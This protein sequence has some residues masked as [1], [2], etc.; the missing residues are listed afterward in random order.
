MQVD[1]TD[2]V[3]AAR[4]LERQLRDAAGCDVVIALSH[5]RLHNDLK[6]AAQ[7]PGLDLILSGHDHEYVVAVGLPRRATARDIPASWE[8]VRGALC[9]WRYRRQVWHRLP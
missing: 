1:Y 5:M 2:F 8:Q 9:G 6:L 3:V 4:E 7:V